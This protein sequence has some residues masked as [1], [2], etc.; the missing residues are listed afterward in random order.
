MAAP[1]VAG[2][3]PDTRTSSGLAWGLRA[4]IWLLP[5]HVLGVAVLVGLFGLPIPIVRLVAAWK[6]SLVAALV[7]VALWRAARGR[8]DARPIVATDLA[9]AALPLVALAYLAGAA[10]WFDAGL[11]A[12]LQVLGWRDAVYF[13]LL[14]AVGRTTPDVADDRRALRA[15]FAVGVITCLVAVLERLIVSPQTLVVLGA[16]RYFQEF[17]NLAPTTHL[18]EYGLPDNYWTAIGDHVVRRAGS[19]YLSSQGFAVPFLLVLPAATLWL[20]AGE[21]RRSIPT[22]AGYAL[23][24]TG[25]LLTV[26][27]MTI[28]VCVLQVF[29]LAAVRR[30]WDV[31]IGTALLGLVG[32]IVALL[33]VPG[34]ATF[35]WDTLTWQTGSSVAH[36]SDWSEGIESLIDHPLG[37]GLGAGGLTA[38]R[39]GLPATAADSQFFKYSVEMGIPGLVLYA[40]MLLAIAAAGLKLARRGAGPERDYGAFLAVSILGLALNG[41]TTLP[42][43]TNFFA[44]VLFWLAGVVVTRAARAA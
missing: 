8:F 6:E 19:T 36:L 22:A 4:F 24:W 17:L 31:A 9:V 27:R 23:L 28:A 34:L 29:L 10:P 12:G 30:R 37:I 11:P 20:F 13:T 41:V 14:Y 3:P 5:F 16:A 33:V 42:L 32:V 18:N 1:E 7:V 38:V 39:F 35:A 43:T 44:Y 25:L 2:A 15:M 26:A 21:R 40:A